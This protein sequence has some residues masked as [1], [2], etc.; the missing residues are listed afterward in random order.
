[1]LERAINIP[2][3][4]T[5]VTIAPSK[6]IHVPVLAWVALSYM[7]VFLDIANAKRAKAPSIARIETKAGAILPI[8]II[9]SNATSPSIRERANN[10]PLTDLMTP[11]AL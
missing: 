9:D 8:G 11:S 1:M 2:P 10:I 6:A 5:T 3:S 4:A 7:L